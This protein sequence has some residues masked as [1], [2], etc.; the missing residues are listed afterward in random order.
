MCVQA[1][2]LFGCGLRVGDFNLDRR[3]RVIK[4]RIVHLPSFEVV[5]LKTWIGEDVELFGRFWEQCRHDGS[6]DVLRQ[7]T[8]VQAGKHTQGFMLGVS[9][10]EQ[11]PS[12]RN[13]YYMIAVEMAE[14]AVVPC[15]RDSLGGF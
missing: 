8:G 4:H 1:P 5:G 2:T 10:V 13:F 11:D 14:G 15:A 7:I 6:L 3:Y 12:N 9:R